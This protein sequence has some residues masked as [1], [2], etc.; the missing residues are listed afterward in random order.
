MTKAA[1]TE[2]AL[3]SQ[4]AFMQVRRRTLPYPLFTGRTAT[5]L[6]HAG[7]RTMVAS[8]TWLSR[9]SLRIGAS[10]GINA[11][12]R[13]VPDRAQRKVLDQ[14]FRIQHDRVRLRDVRQQLQQRSARHNGGGAAAERAGVHIPASSPRWQ[15]RTLYRHVYTVC[16]PLT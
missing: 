4:L 2:A 6:A 7:Q 8:M 1:Q 12:L 3:H 16:S 14:Q 13:L 9:V 15:V 10:P 11:L 5:A